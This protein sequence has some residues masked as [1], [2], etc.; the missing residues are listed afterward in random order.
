M[1]G[2]GGTSTSCHSSAMSPDIPR[3]VKP[4]PPRPD[5]PRTIRP[6]RV[7]PVDL[8][9]VEKLC[10]I[11]HRRLRADPERGL[12]RLP[13]PAPGRRSGEDQGALRGPHAPGR[14]SADEAGSLGAS[15]PVEDV[16][17]IL[18]RVEQAQLEAVVFRQSDGAVLSRWQCPQDEDDLFAA[19]VSHVVMQ[20][21]G[22]RP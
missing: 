21:V 7:V 15:C 16:F 18:I 13:V 14:H 2:T 8:N 9:E 6:L 17:Q 4:F 20:L 11:E 19:G 1:P 3:L 12:Q 5:V 22:I 10:E